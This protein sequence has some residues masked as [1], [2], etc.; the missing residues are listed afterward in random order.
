MEGIIA[1][2]LAAAVLATLG[3]LVVGIVG[4]A[5]GGE[6]NKRYSNK[7]MR[8]RILTQGVAIVLFIILMVVS[9]K[10]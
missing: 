2:L 8:L 7:L 3:V 6:F 10:S 5:R 4:M 1:G 9:G